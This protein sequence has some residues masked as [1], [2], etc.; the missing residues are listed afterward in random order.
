MKSISILIS[1]VLITAFH[2]FTRA[3]NHIPQSV[4]GNGGIT[5]TNPSYRVC[6]TVGQATIGIVNNGINLHKIG[7][8]YQSGGFTTAMTPCTNGWPSQYQLIQNYPNPFN[9]TTTIMFSI[10]RPTSAILKVF[11]ILGVE[12]ATLLNAQLEPGVYKIIFKATD[13]PTGC[14][15]YH[16]QADGFIQTRK[17]LVLK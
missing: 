13:L 8:W 10:P 5:M 2:E 4:F 17:F 1:L 6:G 11:D 7:F 15:F 14:Y 16:L 12:I 3:Q 9:P